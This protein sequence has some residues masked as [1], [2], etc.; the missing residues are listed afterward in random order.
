MPRYD[1]D[2]ARFEDPPPYVL[3]EDQRDCP[4]SLYCL[5]CARTAAKNIVSSPLP[6]PLPTIT[7][8]SSPYPRPRCLLLFL[9]A[10]KS[11]RWSISKSPLPSPS[12]RVH[13]DWILFYTSSFSFK[14]DTYHIGDGVYLPP[15]TYSFPVKGKPAPSKK[16]KEMQVRQL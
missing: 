7:L 2:T 11:L 3:P 15:G 13:H 14:N 8:S 12:P 6:F 1:K 16:Q 5:S 10:R 4:Y 9:Q